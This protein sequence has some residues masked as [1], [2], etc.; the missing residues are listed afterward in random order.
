MR[1]G[2][3]LVLLLSAVLKHKVAIL[4][5]LSANNP[6]GGLYAVFSSSFV[7]LSNVATSTL[8]GGSAQS[9]AFASGEVFAT[10]LAAENIAAEGVNGTM[11]GTARVVAASSSATTTTTAETKTV[12]TT[13]SEPPK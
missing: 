5:N 4:Q 2:V 9:T 10:G 7:A 3:M 12:T 1:R 13:V 11:L 6:N 8:S